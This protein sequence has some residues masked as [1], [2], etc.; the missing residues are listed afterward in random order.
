MNITGVTGLTT[1]HVATLKVL[2]AVE[3]LLMAMNARLDEPEHSD[4]E[5]AIASLRAQ[6]DEA[7][8][9]IAW[10]EGHSLT[11][12]QAITLARQSE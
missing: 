12:E 3:A 10:K 2:G 9:N 1:A 7:S 4:K 5:R 11:L 6:L 8:F